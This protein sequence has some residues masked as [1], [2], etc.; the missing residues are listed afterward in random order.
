MQSSHKIEVR[1]MRPYLGT[2]VDV[3]VSG[4]N[5]RD[6]LASIDRAFDCVATVEE[7]M[8]AHNPQSDLGRLYRAG[9]NEAVSVHPW[10]YRVISAAKK[11]HR[12]SDGVFDITVG[13]VLEGNGFL[14]QWR[15]ARR[16]GTRGTM[17][18]VEL[19][20]DNVV[21][22]RRRVRLD[23][24][25]IAKGFAVDRAVRPLIESGAVAGCVNAGGD[26]RIFGDRGEPLLLRDPV[27][28]GRILQAGEIQIGAAATSAGYFRRRRKNSATVIPLVDGRNRSMLNRCDS[29]T[30]LASTCM[31]ADALTKVLAVDLQRGAAMLGHFNAKA[32]LLSTSHQSS[33]C[34]LLPEAK[35][36][37]Y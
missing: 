8:S 11:L 34:R 30:V 25:G 13:D 32:V 26:F 35:T 33:T 19:L 36:Y 22:P 16:T 9:K 1:R 15:A 29:I 12:L 21:R 17:A 3:R 5:E 20:D 6:A 7:K 14:P 18:D 10:T 24:G 23:L 28:P 2:F 4:L 31:W 37:R 27:H